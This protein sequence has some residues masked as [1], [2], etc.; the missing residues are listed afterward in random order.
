MFEAIDIIK[1]LFVSGLTG[2]DTK[3]SGQFYKLESTRLWTMPEV[4]PEIFVATAGPV[5]AKRAGRTVDGLI[6]ETA[7]LDKV[8]VLLQ[9]FDEG[10][11]EAGRPGTRVL[12]LHVS[13]A[14][15]DELAMANALAEWP[16]G[17]M[18]F[19]KGDIRSPF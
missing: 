9:R 10:T 12:R 2:R 5:T 1:K 15:T 11:R 7:A 8:E 6:T 3:H 16:N 19:A 13:W 18:K 14:E 17:A 4:A